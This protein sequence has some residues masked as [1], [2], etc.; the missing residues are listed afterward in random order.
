MTTKTRLQKAERAHYART[1]GGRGQ[2]FVHF[3]GHDFGTLDGVRISLTDYEAIKSE[4]DTVINVLYQE[5]GK[6]VTDF[7]TKRYI[8]V[9]PLDWDKTS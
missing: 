1:H 6:R 9:S 7:G 8:D 5:D 3:E 2:I 4:N